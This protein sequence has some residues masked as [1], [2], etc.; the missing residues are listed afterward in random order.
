MTQPKTFGV[1]GGFAASD[2]SGIALFLE[3]LLARRH[4]GRNMCARHHSRKI[5]EEVSLFTLPSNGL[6]NAP[7][8]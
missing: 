8:A 6:Q 5:N 1:G 4:L 3:M 2:F 7:H